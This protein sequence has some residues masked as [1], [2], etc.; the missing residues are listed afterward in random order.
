MVAVVDTGNSN[1]G[2]LQ[3]EG[4][5]EG[6]GDGR[7]DPW[8][9]VGFIIGTRKESSAKVTRD[10]S[11][12]VDPGKSL[13]LNNGILTFRILW[14]LSGLMVTMVKRVQFWGPMMLCRV[15]EASA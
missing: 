4:L 7:N 11:L 10:S 15:K 5:A 6:D 14:V 12:Q 8:Q 13:T 1:G 9:T 2:A 3:K